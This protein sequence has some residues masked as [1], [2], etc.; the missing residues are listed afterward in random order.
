[1]KR[2]P[3]KQK[4]VLGPWIDQLFEARAERLALERN[5][6]AMKGHEQALRVQILEKLQELAITKAS[7]DRATFSFR[8]K[9]V[10]TVMDWNAVEKWIAKHDAFDLL[11]RRLHQ[12]AW[13][14]RVEAGQAIPGVERNTILDVSVTK[15][16]AA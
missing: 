10:G 8:P 3:K 7:G 11:Q 12:G 9:P 16:G 6:E 4:P 1:M 15:K 14:E 2:V 13:L 5:V